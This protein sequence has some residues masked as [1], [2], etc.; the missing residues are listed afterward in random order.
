MLALVLTHY[1]AVAVCVAVV[2]YAGVRL[3]GRERWRVMGVALAAG[4]VFAVIWGPEMLAQ[5]QGYAIGDNWL[6]DRGA[7]RLG[8]LG[9]QL[10][11][12]PIRLFAE[13]PRRFVYGVVGFLLMVLPMAR[14][15]RVRGLLLPLMWAWGWIGMM[16]VIDLVRSTTLTMVPR[17]ALGAAPAVYLLGA[18]IFADQRGRR[19]W[20]RHVLPG[21]L[22]IY[23][24]ASLPWA[25]QFP[26]IDFRGLGQDVGR[27]VGRDDLIIY[28]VEGI[29]DQFTGVPMLAVDHYAPEVSAAAVLATG[30]LR[31]EAL[32]R[33]RRARRVWGVSNV[34]ALDVERV[35]PGF[36]IRERHY[37]HGFGFLF[38]LERRG[39]LEEVPA[40]AG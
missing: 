28:H 36:G 17:F 7:G 15:K 18:G 38:G 21:V 34:S 22:V 39:A 24:L 3:R 33:A 40:P 37:A 11:V 31:G 23:C 6:S 20:M 5:G 16:G 26:K 10:L 14:V 1:L 13:P 30:P 9:W 12:L 4:V 32:E 2:G 25:Y 27:L 29:G 19:G 35:V 8:R